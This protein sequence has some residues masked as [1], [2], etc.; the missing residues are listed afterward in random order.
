MIGKRRLSYSYKLSAA[1]LPIAVC[2]AYPH[3]I[4]KK[5][6]RCL[7]LSSPLDP[8]Q[9][10]PVSQIWSKCVWRYVP[11]WQKKKGRQNFCSGYV[12]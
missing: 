1:F 7:P 9:G 4:V 3:V 11:I 5:N 2:P 6:F 12:D 10:L 8:L